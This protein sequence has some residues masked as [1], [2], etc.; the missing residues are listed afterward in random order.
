MSKKATFESHVKMFAIILAL[1]NLAIRAMPSNII[2][3]IWT[4]GLF[5][6]KCLNASEEL[7]SFHVWHAP[8][9]AS[10]S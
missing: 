9:T 5:A 2:V 6:S 4:K 10:F 8:N 1:F 3:Y 7:Y